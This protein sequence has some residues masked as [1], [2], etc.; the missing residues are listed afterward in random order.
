MGLMIVSVQIGGRAF[1]LLVRVCRAS[2]SKKIK[3]LVHFAKDFQ[4][5]YTAL[6][7]RVYYARVVSM[8]IHLFQGS[9]ARSSLV[10]SA[11]FV[12]AFGCQKRR[13][14]N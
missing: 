5:Q 10:V 2:V 9:G 6:V 11:S 13:V 8:K 14:M 12:S 7:T 1:S 4:K 3:W